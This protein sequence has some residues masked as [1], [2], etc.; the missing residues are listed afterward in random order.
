MQGIGNPSIRTKSSYR[1]LYGSHARTVGG[2]SSWQ[3][4]SPKGPN[5]SSVFLMVYS[6]VC[7]SEPFGSD[8][9]ERCMC[10]LYAIAAPFAVGCAFP[11]VDRR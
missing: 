8:R 9:S 2:L 11:R 6:H 4:I 10:Q 5:I 7:C 3:E 1:S